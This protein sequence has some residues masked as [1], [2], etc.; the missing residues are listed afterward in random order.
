MPQHSRSATRIIEA[1]PAVIFD[2]LSD[3]RQHPRIDGSGTVRASI[4]GPERLELGST[5]GND[6]KVGATYKIK[7]RVVEYEKDR[8]IAWRHYSPHRWR[9]ELEPVEQGVRVTETWDLAKVPPGLRFGL[10]KLF[11][12]RTQAA[13]EETLL[14]LKVAA[15]D[16]AKGATS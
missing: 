4:S 6:M 2:I 9:Y 5:F 12:E 3:P 7:N 13:L 14:K 15:E 11:G 1:P 10:E 16:D 8:L